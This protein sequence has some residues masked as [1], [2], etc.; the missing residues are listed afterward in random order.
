L[1]RHDTASWLENKKILHK[2]G[3]ECKKPRLQLV[4]YWVD[5]HKRARIAHSYIMDRIMTQLRYSTGSTQQF[6]SARL[7]SRVA[8]AIFSLTALGSFAFSTAATAQSTTPAAS[9]TVTPAPSA[10]P[11]AEAPKVDAT[12]VDAAKPADTP[13]APSGAAA[14]K[15]PAGEKAQE[16]PYGLKALV[17]HGDPVDGATLLILLIMSMGSWY[18]IFTK[19]LEQSKMKKQADAA[20]KTFWSAGTVRQGADTLATGSPFRFI[21]EQALESTKKHDGLL[22]HVDLN[23]FVTQSIER[24][25]SNVQSRTQ[26]GLAFL[27]TVGSTAPF[28]GLFGTVWGIYNALVKIGLSGQASIDKV[29]GPVGSALIMTAIGLA[30]AVPAVLG[31]NW[32]VRRNK[33]GME[34]VREFGSDLHS[35]ILSAQKR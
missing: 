5:A 15:P 28:V 18:V 10:T 32:L 1:F 35:A 23:T 24:S 3:S 22:A 7:S 12:K 20:K 16:N 25:T 29:A 14:V 19:F 9:G 2:N 8:A 21:T 11:A 34:T 6:I 30:V 4:S 33:A 13:A 31:Y 26:D 27:A 17:S